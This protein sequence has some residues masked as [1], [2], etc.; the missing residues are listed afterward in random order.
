MNQKEN[1]LKPSNEKNIVQFNFGVMQDFF[2]YSA[3]CVQ[4]AR[5]DINLSEPLCPAGIRGGAPSLNFRRLN[6]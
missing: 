3:T 1:L 5:E 6:P 2:A 4:Y